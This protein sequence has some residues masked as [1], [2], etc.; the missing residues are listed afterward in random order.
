MPHDSGEIRAYLRTKR[1]RIAAGALILASLAVAT[2]VVPFPTLTALNVVI[3]GAIPYGLFSVGRALWHL[4]RSRARSAYSLLVALLCLLTLPLMFL[5]YH[6]SARKARAVAEHVVAS[7]ERYRTEH[8]GYPKSMDVLVPQYL[9]KVPGCHIDRARYLL[10]DD[11][12]Y[13]V[14]CSAYLYMRW[15]YHSG[16]GSWTLAD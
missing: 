12:S 11:G 9:P 7:V 5:G 2:Q 3:L 4:R 13:A 10:L 8:D 15:S 16:T 6:A 14:V 1:L